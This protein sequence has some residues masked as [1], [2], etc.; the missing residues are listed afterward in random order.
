[1]ENESFHKQGGP[2]KDP[3]RVSY[4][5]TGFIQKTL[6]MEEEEELDDWLLASKENMR[7]FEE[8]TDDKKM[9]DYLGW[10]D[11]S[12]AEQRL[13]QARGSLQLP[14]RKKEFV[15]W[16]YAAAVCLLVVAV[17]LINYMRM[18]P[19]EEAQPM[20][21]A[22]VEPGNEWARLRLE[23]GRLLLLQA[24]TLIN[25]QLKVQDGALMY[26][27]DGNGEAQ[28]HELYVPRKGYY[29]LVLPDGSVVWLNSESSIRYPSRFVGQSRE[30]EVSGETFFEVAKDAG[31]P[32]IVKLGTL[33][34]QALGTAFNI[35]AYPDEGRIRTTLVEGSV[36]VWDA[37]H[38]VLLGPS[39]Q[40]ETS[41]KEWMHHKNLETGDIIA[42]KEN[43]F[44]LKNKKLEEVMRLAARWYDIEVNYEDTVGYHFNGRISRD[45]PLR[46]LLELLEQTG[47]VHFKVE[48]RRVTVSR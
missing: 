46:R 34:V 36:K 10:Y 47:H 29:R 23:D 27:S 41:D 43:E 25:A 38:Q 30:V 13:R 7:L 26:G 9:Q 45:V 48:G 40:I 21:A 17:V 32:F 12:K 14:P 8:L 15:L 2:P 1:M 18:K 20:A 19:V 4:L 16:K 24:D 39:E 3:Y 28:W 33:R 35:N 22:E 11:E 37:E 31:K 6:T 5:V 42:W 44:R